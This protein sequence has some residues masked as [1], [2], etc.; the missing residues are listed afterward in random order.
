MSD[1]TV[2]AKTSGASPGEKKTYSARAVCAAYQKLLKVFRDPERTLS[3][4]S[5]SCSIPK[6]HVRSIVA[7]SLSSA[8]SK[9][10]TVHAAA[11]EQPSTHASDVQKEP[12][13]HLSAPDPS[14]MLALKHYALRDA[15]V[16]ATVLAVVHVPEGAFQPALEAFQHHGF[17]ELPLFEQQNEYQRAIMN[18]VAQ[19]LGIHVERLCAGVRNEQVVGAEKKVG[20]ASSPDVPLDDSLFWYLIK[21]VREELSARNPAWSAR[22]ISLPPLDLSRL[23]HR[24]NT[25]LMTHTDAPPDTFV[26][27]MIDAAFLRARCRDLVFVDWVAKRWPQGGMRWDVVSEIEFP[28]WLISLL[29]YTLYSPHRLDGK[30]MLVRIACVCA[31][32]AQRWAPSNKLR[33]YLALAE[34]WVEE[35]TEEN[36]QVAEKAKVEMHAPPPEDQ[37]PLGPAAYAYQAAF[38]AT[39][40]AVSAAA[41]ADPSRVSSHAARAGAA[42]VMAASFASSA[43]DKTSW[44]EMVSARSAAGE[45]AEQKEICNAIRVLVQKQQCASEPMA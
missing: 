7:A 25:I 17:K 41:A 12:T 20:R 31:A 11:T 30:Q 18:Y 40:R 37:P 6:E 14:A 22:Y 21:P 29:S 45:S 24:S 33:H 43:S 13:T 27:D 16:N 10:P 34:C 39:Q 2:I 19:V 42:A 23:T 32:R 3:L 38:E 8:Q 36:R 1:T 35:P 15:D 5:K 26:V 4:V 28:D 44:M 9:T